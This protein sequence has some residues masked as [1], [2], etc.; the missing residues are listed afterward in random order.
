M[1][2]SIIFLLKSVPLLIACGYLYRMAISVRFIHFLLNHEPVSISSAMA[3]SIPGKP[4]L[5]TGVVTLGNPLYSPLTRTPCAAWRTDID[6]EYDTVVWDSATEGYGYSGASEKVKSRTETRDFILDDGT[7][8]I[9]CRIENAEIDWK[10]LRAGAMDNAEL[11]DP[12]LSMRG[13]GTEFL[14]FRDV[15]CLR[16]FKCIEEGLPLAQRVLLTGKVVSEEGKAYLGAPG[17]PLPFVIHQQFQEL[18]LRK[19][20]IRL[21]LDGVIL[22]LFSAIGVAAHVYL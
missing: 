4:Q 12:D 14:N 10:I 5:F 18:L 6:V 19:T 11:S 15:V 3:G 13:I 1:D 17:W 9:L 16:G 21:A 2:K 20:R 8:Q 7:G 22:L